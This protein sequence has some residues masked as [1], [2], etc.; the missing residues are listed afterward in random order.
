[1]HAQ[2]VIGI[3]VASSKFYKDGLY[4]LDFKHPQAKGSR[5]LTS[6]A[7]AEIYQNYLPN[8]PIVF[9]E[10]VF[11]EDDFESWTKFHV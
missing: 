4:D 1:M 7:V 8:Y 3:D 5:L 9:I 11:A 10:D 6:N 2:V